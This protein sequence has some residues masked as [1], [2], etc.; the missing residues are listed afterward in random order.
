MYDG[1]DISSIE[2]KINEAK[3]GY[4]ASQRDEGQDLKNEYDLTVD[5]TEEVRR[6]LAEKHNNKVLS[7]HLHEIIKVEDPAPGYN[8]VL[9]V[10][11]S[12]NIDPETEYVITSFFNNVN[13]LP[14]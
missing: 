9:R 2:F 13:I 12:T 11:Y 7:L 6:L 4:F 8:Q 1:T 5:V 14:I 3:Y 10:K